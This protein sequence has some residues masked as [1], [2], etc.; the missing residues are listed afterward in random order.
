LSKV[1]EL[2]GPV[3]DPER[4]ADEIELGLKTYARGAPDRLLPIFDFFEGELGLIE[5]ALRFYA[6]ALAGAV[7]GAWLD[8]PAGGLTEGPAVKPKKPTESAG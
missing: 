5:R 4:L 1:K 6:S 3:S 7:R 8:Q 2:R